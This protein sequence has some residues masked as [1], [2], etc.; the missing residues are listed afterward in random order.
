MGPGINHRQKAMCP[1]LN[2]QETFAIIYDRAYSFQGARKGLPIDVRGCQRLC[3]GRTRAT[4]TVWSSSPDQCQAPR[5]ARRSRWAPGYLNREYLLSGAG[6]TDRRRRAP[7]RV[8]LS[9][10]IEVKV[11]A[12]LRRERFSDTSRSCRGSCVHRPA[13]VCSCLLVHGARQAFD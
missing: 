11:N 6:N 10:L 3:G 12:L 13:H 9:A 2:G 8:G 4:I 7:A 5:R 1:I